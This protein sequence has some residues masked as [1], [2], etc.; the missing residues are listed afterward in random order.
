VQ[1]RLRFARADAERLDNL[2][3]DDAV[4]Q[5]SV[6][7]AHAN[8]ADLERE[9]ATT[10][11]ALVRS[12]ERHRAA[13]DGVFLLEDGTDGNSTFHR[14]ADARLQL[15]Q[16]ESSL[17]QLRAEE[18]A[19]AAVLQAALQAY[20]KSRSLDITVPPG[21]MV[22]TLTAGPGAPVQPGSP[23]ASWV[24]CSV[25]LVDVP[26]S[27]VETSLLHVGSAAEVVFEGERKLRRGVVLLTRG[28]AGILGAH[29]LAALAKGRRPGIGQAIVKLAA[30]SDDIRACPIGHAAYAD[31]PG[32]G[33]FQILRARLRW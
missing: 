33:A 31:F 20:D 12:T 22:W 10:E 19:A 11:A 28:S 5:A 16:A 13:K 3:R 4:S 18:A 17:T 8:V 9:L 30:D 29:D 2:Y 15:V 26:L 24:D 25:L 27:D 1:T 6:D 23:V 7:A 14:L 32:I 21:V